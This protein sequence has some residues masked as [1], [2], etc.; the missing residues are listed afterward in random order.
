MTYF[1]IKMVETATKNNPRA[2]Q[3][4]EHIYG[5]G[6]F[7]IA[8][9]TPYCSFDA[10]E[11]GLKNYGYTRKCD[12]VRALKSYNESAEWQTSRGYWDTTCEIVSFER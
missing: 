4:H 12:V 10:N 5:K 11:Y 3:V 2:G 9:N 1:G 8:M 6:G 7:T